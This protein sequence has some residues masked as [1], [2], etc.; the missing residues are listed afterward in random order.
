MFRAN[1]HFTNSEKFDAY[2]FVSAGYRGSSITFTSNDPNAI[3]SS[4]SFIPFG[5]KPGVGFRY[6]FTDNIGI[7]A[8]IAIGT[9]VMGGGLSFKF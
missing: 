1:F 9:P 8:E 2:G 7:N 6:F 5:L 4:Y 3:K